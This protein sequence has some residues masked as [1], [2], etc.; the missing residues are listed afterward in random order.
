LRKPISFISLP[1]LLSALLAGILFFAA[2]FPILTQDLVITTGGDGIKNYFTPVWSVAYG[3]GP[4]FTGMHYPYGDN[5]VYTDNQ[6][7]VSHIISILSGPLGIEG[8][9]VPRI[10]H[11]LMLFTAMICAG[12]MAAILSRWIDNR[13]WVVLLALLITCMAPQIDRMYA[14]FS[15]AYTCFFPLMWYLL[16]RWQDKEWKALAAVPL[17]AAMVFFAFIH[18]YYLLIA[19]LCGL[20]VLL[21]VGL[22]RMTSWKK[23][24]IGMVI[25]CVPFLLVWTYTYFTDPVTDRPSHPFGF[26]FYKA[27]FQSVF[28]PSQGWLHNL[29]HNKLHFGS[30]NMEGYAWVGHTGLAALAIGLTAV[31]G[32]WLKRH[33]V[34]VQTPPT[35]R[36]WLIASVLVLAFSMTLPFSLGLEGLL[37]VIPFIQQ[38]RS[39]GRFAWVFYFVFSA[40]TGILL[41]QLFRRAVNA[42][43]WVS[44]VLLVIWGI[45]SMG[46]LYR[47]GERIDAQAGANAFSPASTTFITNLVPDTESYQAILQLPFYHMGSEKLYVDKGAHFMAEGMTTA[48]ATGLPMVN[49]MGSRTSIGQSLEVSALAGHP[50]IQKTIPDGFNEKDLLL[51]TRDDA[52]N[53]P[54][55][56]LTG[57][58]VLL[59][60]HQ[61]FSYYRLPLSAFNHT[62]QELLDDFLAGKDS[63]YLNRGDYFSKEELAIWGRMGD[64]APIGI[65]VDNDVDNDFDAVV[66]VDAVAI[67]V[68]RKGV[69]REGGEAF[70]MEVPVKALDSATWMEVSFWSY[71]F[72]ETTAYPPVKV[73][74]LNSSGEVIRREDVTAK[75]STDIIG[76]W[77]RASGYYEVTPDCVSIRLTLLDH[78]R[79]LIN[80][81][82][83]RDTRENAFYRVNDGALWFNNFPI[84]D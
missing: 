53:I 30:M 45:D 78:P 40:W 37:D 83:V 42:W 14:H 6:P 4:W 27:S 70:L 38:F 39:P 72:N 76:R 75:F 9:E 77:V 32:R 64:D 79:S 1:S 56:F 84:N 2:F 33:W 49:Q 22:L 26:F 24:L 15:L 71:T 36:I 43:K 73:E 10:L 21:V 65:G 34:P 3:E 13:V 51:I 55:Q 28:I 16:L 5:V 17:V 18:L 81:I 41:Y 19:M 46:Y 23:V 58:A 52:L 11:W 44:L 59:G 8:H 69:Y 50:L 67:G 80:N 12:L 61:G 68:D 82:L 47:T 54:E 20:V 57:R 25:L 48:Y 29:W 63:V 62:Q 74:W 35:F 7:A 31:L 66:D 60:E